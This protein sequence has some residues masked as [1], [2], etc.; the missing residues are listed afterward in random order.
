MLNYLVCD[1]VIQNVK[2]INW[3]L[4]AVQRRDFFE[5]ITAFKNERLN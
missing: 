4:I 5:K 1:Y 3:E 2:F